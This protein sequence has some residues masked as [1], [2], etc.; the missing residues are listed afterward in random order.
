MKTQSI[1][2][3]GYTATNTRFIVKTV[4]ADLSINQN[5]S[6]SEPEGPNPYE[7]I[8]AGL[9]GCLN[10]LGHIVAKEQGLVLRSLQIEIRA[11]L[12]LPEPEKL[13]L[14]RPVFTNIEIAL[15]PS[16]PATIVALQAWHSEVQRRSPLYENLVNNT[17]VEEV[18]L[19]DFS[20]N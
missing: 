7:Y 19:R 20:F 17:P 13:A 3:L 9:A 1:N 10:A 11:A 16:T 12:M 14:E 18:L 6:F 5:L 15:K 8:L 4:N 2:V